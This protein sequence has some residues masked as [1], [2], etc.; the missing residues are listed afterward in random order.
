[1]LYK[2]TNDY[3]LTDAELSDIKLLAKVDNVAETFGKDDLII[4]LQQ[5]LQKL[6]DKM[7][8][9]YVLQQKRV[10]SME[11]DIANFTKNIQQ[12]RS[13]L[14]ILN[15]QKNHIED[16]IVYLDQDKQFV[17]D[18]FDE[19]NSSMMSLEKQKNRMEKI[20]SSTKNFI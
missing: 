19:L 7:N 17:Q 5:E 3:Y 4:L 12:Y 20:T 18:Q 6:F 13:K 8:A 1:M 15:Q 9:I 2:I 16:L 11:S 14:K 10:F